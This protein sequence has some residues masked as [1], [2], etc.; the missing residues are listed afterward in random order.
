MAT[1]SRSEQ[2]KVNGSR[3][4]GPSS[5]EG[6]LAVRKNALKHGFTAVEL[7]LPNETPEL[8]QEHA[9]KLF[10]SLEPITNHEIELANQGALASIRYARIAKSEAKIVSEQV[11][12]AEVEWEL[13][14]KTKL[15]GLKELIKKKPGLAVIQLK[16]FAEG[17][18]WLAEEWLMLEMSFKT[19]NSFLHFDGIRAA[20]RLLGFNP[21]KL[22][23]ESL[24][25]LEFTTRALACQPDGGKSEISRRKIATDLHF[26]CKYAGMIDSMGAYDKDESVKE[27]KKWINDEL[28]EL[29][30]R[31]MRLEDIE[32]ASREGAKT[33]ASLSN[34]RPRTAFSFAIPASFSASSRESSRRS[35]KPAK[36]ARKWRKS[37]RK[38]PLRLTRNRRDETNPT[39]RPTQAQGPF[40]QGLTSLSTI[41]AMKSG[42][43]RTTRLRLLISVMT[44][45]GGVV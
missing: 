15:E 40:T 42:R 43:R 8:I 26:G 41:N 3:S 29:R 28:K 25:A 31:I 39:W 38:P 16:S 20:L 4:R 24:R 45:C 6:K 33:R 37:T 14:Q 22:D 11:R 23:E 34:R 9:E 21:D 13:A 17:V 35:R 12:Q 1:L 36:S 7:T 10:E 44:R 19:M 18:R 27:I 2:S 32:T 5:R 30:T